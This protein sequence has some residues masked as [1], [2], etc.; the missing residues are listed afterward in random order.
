M[1]TTE[2]ITSIGTLLTQ[3][4]WKL[5]T[6]ESCT[7][8]G[9]AYVITEQAGVSD[10]FERGYV[11]YSNAAKEA[12]LQVP[13]TTLLQFGAVSEQTA[14]AMAEGALQQSQA[15]VSVAITGIA[16][17]GGGTPTKPVGTVWFGWASNQ[18]PTQTYVALFSGNRTDIRQ[19]AIQ[20]AL[21]KLLA[22]IRSAMATK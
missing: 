3:Q 22:F 21:E 9:L 13:A 8:G 11:T 15:Q 4:Q 2:L 5:V 18:A 20:T 14:R 19:Q 6:A 17:P 12:N 1:I 7:G 10:W 16:G